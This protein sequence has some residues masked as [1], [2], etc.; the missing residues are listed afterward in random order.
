MRPKQKITSSDVA[1]LAGVSQATVSK[2]ANNSAVLTAATRA[3]VIQAAHD[4]GYN[5][6]PRNS[7]EYHFALVFPGGSIEGYSSDLLS[8]L[9]VDLLK[10][11]IRMDIVPGNNLEIL[12]ER[13]VNG[14]IAINWE[15]DFYE[16]YKRTLSLPL[17]RIG[18]ASSHHED[19]YSVVSDG[20]TSL[21]FLVDKLWAL[22]HRKIGFFF[23]DTYTH[24]IN[25][26]SRR[27]EGFLQAMKNHGVEEPEEF[28]TYNCMERDSNEL[29]LLLKKW[30]DS[31]VTA[32]IFAN[33]YGT[34]KMM[35]IIRMTNIIVPREMSVIGWEFSSVSEYMNPPLCTLDM[36]PF[37]L[38]AE[39][40]KL[41]KQILNKKANIKDVY[42][43]YK[44]I[45]R[46]SVAPARIA[47]PDQG[48]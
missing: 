16:R 33:A 23:F 41:L 6:T 44:Y 46:E 17:V 34:G 9:I 8:G 40:V 29:S 31:G 25:N 4:L 14:V 13:C 32:L 45:E 20:M 22:N 19:I 42:L 47:P 36:E 28:C 1:R 30:Y 11:K 26:Q 43:P 35:K 3:K 18:G 24:E 48:A 12:N 15:K 7:G 27:R 2:V 38:A 5:L 39:A 10:Q 37:K 21:K